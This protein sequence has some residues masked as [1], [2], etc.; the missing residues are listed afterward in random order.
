MIPTKTCAKGNQQYSILDVCKLWQGFQAIY[1]CDCCDNVDRS[2]VFQ[3]GDMVYVTV[4]SGNVLPYEQWKIIGQGR[5]AL[6][7]TLRIKHH[8]GEIQETLFELAFKMPEEAMDHARKQ[9]RQYEA[10]C[11]EVFREQVKRILSQPP[12]TSR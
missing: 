2:P 10:E 1:Y 9:L 8:T 6:P 7:A 3:S 12:T 5:V 11:L 4:A